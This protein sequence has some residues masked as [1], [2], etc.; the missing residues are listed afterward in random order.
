MASFIRCRTGIAASRKFFFA[1]L[2]VS[3]AIYSAAI[4]IESLV[5]KEMAAHSA[6]IR[7]VVGSGGG[8]PLQA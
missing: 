5:K 1:A 3:G 8:L 7:L 4:A 6:A 2:L